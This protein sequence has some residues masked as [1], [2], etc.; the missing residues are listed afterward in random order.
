[1]SN[2]ITAD[3]LKRRM[4]GGDPPLIVDVMPPSQYLLLHLPGAINIPL[5][6]VH[7]VLEYLPR[8]QDMVF[9]CTNE[10]CEL[11]KVAAKKLE[12]HGFTNVLVFKGGLAE[13]ENAGYMFSTILLHAV[14]EEEEEM[15]ERE[16][17]A[18]AAPA[19]IAPSPPQADLEPAP[20]T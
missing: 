1:M 18:S 13:W 5:E 14:D 17:A 6:Y 7:E 9:Y 15:G 4:D 8:E 3:E 19:E 12:L 10:D 11:S 16:P 20:A 2:E